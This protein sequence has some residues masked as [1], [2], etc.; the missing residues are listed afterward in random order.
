MSTFTLS[1]GQ[2]DTNHRSNDGDGER[3]KMDQVSL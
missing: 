2:T 3:I 1:T